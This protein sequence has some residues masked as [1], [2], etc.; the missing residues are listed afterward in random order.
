M[1]LGN[2]LLSLFSRIPEDK[3]RFRWIMLLAREV[4]SR[5]FRP[6]KLSL[7]LLSP[8]TIRQD[9]SRQILRWGRKTLLRNFYA[10]LRVA[11][12]N[13]WLKSLK[14]FL[15]IPE[16]HKRAVFCIILL[17]FCSINSSHSNT[18]SERNWN[19]CG[20][21]KNEESCLTRRIFLWKFMQIEIHSTGTRL[22]LNSSH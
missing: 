17:T 1:A 16:S 20:S 10:S 7:W 21:W 18:K 2:V 4:C 6:L 9:Y 14:M 13:L 22:L 12:R 8:T 5:I 19:L 15:D 3:G 11:K